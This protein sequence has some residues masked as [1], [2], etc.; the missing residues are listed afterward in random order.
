MKEKHGMHESAEARLGEIGARLDVVVDAASR[1]DLISGLKAEVA[2]WHEWVDEARLQ[3]ALGAMEGR[4]R[5]EE[6]MR[7]L[8]NLS[9]RMK[10]RLVDLE[11]LSDPVPGLA[12]EVDRQLDQDAEALS[13]GSFSS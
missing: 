7:S 3:L 2:V 1:G 5:F 9:T 10:S 12:E 13:S 4:D 6:G 11:S 8:E